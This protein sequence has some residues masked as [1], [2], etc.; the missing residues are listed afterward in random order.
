MYVNT[1]MIP[2]SEFAKM[3]QAKR[4]VEVLAQQVFYAKQAQIE[5]EVK[6]KKEKEEGFAGKLI[7]A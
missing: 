7:F 5:Y 4:K 2:L 6:L 1:K 3:A